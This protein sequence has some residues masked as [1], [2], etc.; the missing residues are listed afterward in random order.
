MDCSSIEHYV[1]KII[2]GTVGNTK[3]TFDFYLHVPFDPDEVVL[4]TVSYYDKTATKSDNIILF[5]SDL[6]NNEILFTMPEVTFSQEAYNT[7][8]K[9]NRQVGGNYTMSLHKIDGSPWTTHTQPVKLAITLLFI[10]WRNK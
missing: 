10:K 5:R 8:F 1:T 3:N 6:V 9:L 4:K 7:P 2:S